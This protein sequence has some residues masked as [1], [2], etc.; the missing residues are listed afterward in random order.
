MINFKI[1]A[2]GR[3]ILSGEHTVTY[4]KHF[5]VAG[6]DLRTKL[7]FCELLDEPRSIR[8][9]FCGVQQDLSLEKVQ[10]LFSQLN[11]LNMPRFVN[12]FIKGMWKKNEEKLSLQMFFYLLYTI[13]Y[14]SE[15]GMKPF[16]LR[17]FTEIPFE[18]GLGGS[19]SFVVCLAACF[20]HWKRLQSGVHIRFNE[21]DLQEIEEYTRSCENILQ[22][23][24]FATI[25]AKVCVYG[26]INKCKHISSDVYAIKPIVVK[27]GIKILLIGTHLRLT[28]IERDIQVELLSSRSSNFNIILN[29]LN[30]IAI[31]IFDDLNYIN[32]N[33]EDLDAYKN[34]QRDIKRNQQMLSTDMIC[35]IL[36]LI[37]LPVLEVD[38]IWQE[39][40]QVLKAAMYTFCYYQ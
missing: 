2:P 20:L 14:N 16:R 28:E 33:I 12:N 13:V 40:L 6:L 27:T 21:Q 9:E 11:V 3:I 19:T 32:N 23:D 18:N 5:V 22:R 4:E 15:H 1:S 35:R 38:S 29:E 26:R 25:D 10:C 37:L 34:L 39:S 24:A 31:S 17:V 36:N 8:I 7:E 30:E